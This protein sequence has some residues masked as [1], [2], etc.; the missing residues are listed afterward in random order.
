MWKG[1]PDRRPWLLLE[2]IGNDWR[3]MPITTKQ[4][5]RYLFPI[6]PA[7]CD[8]AATGLTRQCFVDY[9]SIVVVQQSELC[10]RRGDLVGDML[11]EFREAAGV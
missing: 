9:E 6:E 7:H 5:G 11:S 2:P 3:A 1:C 10:K 8:F 4:Y